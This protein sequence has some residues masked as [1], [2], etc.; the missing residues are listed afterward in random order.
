MIIHAIAGMDITIHAHVICPVNFKIKKIK[1]ATC[2]YKDTNIQEKTK[3][4]YAVKSYYEAE[5]IRVIS[6]K[7]PLGMDIFVSKVNT[8]ESKE[9]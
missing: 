2:K 8:K 5:G 7:D 6:K 1:K 4:A 3:Y 9:A